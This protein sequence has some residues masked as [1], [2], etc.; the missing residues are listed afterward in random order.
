MQV[1]L[2]AQE[3]RLERSR[4]ECVKEGIVYVQERGQML[5][6]YFSEKVSPGV[7][8]VGAKKQGLN[9]WKQEF[10]HWKF[11][12]K[13][14][15]VK[16]AEGERW[17]K[18]ARMRV[19]MHVQERKTHNEA[20]SDMMIKL[21]S[22][23]ISPAIHDVA[24]QKEA[25]GVWREQRIHALV[26]EKIEDNLTNWEANRKEE[27]EGEIR[28]ERKQIEKDAI[29]QHAKARGNVV[30]KYFSE[31]V[32]A[33][34]HDVSAKKEGFGIWKEEAVRVFMANQ[35]EK[36]CAAIGEEV[37]SDLENAH[38]AERT[39]HNR[40]RKDMLV[41]YFSEKVAPGVHDVAAKKESLGVWKEQLLH[42][43]TAKLHKEQIEQQISETKEQKKTQ[44]AIVAKYLSERVSP[45]V[46]DASAK[47]QG[48]GGWKEHFLHNSHGKKMEDLREKVKAAQE[49]VEFTKAEHEEAGKREE[50]AMRSAPKCGPFVLRRRKKKGVEP[51]SVAQ[52]GSPRT[53]NGMT[54]AAA[55]G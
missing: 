52:P 26:L 35:E 28:E 45:A 42:E 16:L 31:K 8:D 27:L 9:V 21:F 34:V 55:E 6:K 13:E 40:M 11:E 54:L 25:F 23:K 2:K 30:V 41:K 22:E 32:S 3:K 17:K 15:Q 51:L 44:R 14:E 33:A 19:E 20:R 29:K 39:L 49:T 43:A 50:E 18:A 36:R 53:K 38:K 4:E 46:H 10:M 48:F 7:H 1:R 37:R 5:C 24:A 12:E 47:K